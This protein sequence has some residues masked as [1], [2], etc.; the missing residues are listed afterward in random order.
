MMRWGYALLLLF[1]AGVASAHPAP[2]SYLDIY[3]N[4]TGTHGTLTLH[5]YDVAHELGL[6]DPAALLDVNTAQRNQQQLTRLIE[7][8]LQLQAEQRALK[9]DW[10]G[11]EVLAERQ[12]L[13]L[14]F[15]LLDNTPAELAVSAHLFPY[16]AIHQT[17]INIYEAGQLKHQDILDAQ[18]TSMSYYSGSVQ[19]RWAVLRTYL[20][21]GIHHILIG[22]DHILFLFGLLLLGGSLWRLLGIVTAF[23]VGHSITLSLAVLGV[24]RL[25]PSLVEPVI[26]LSVVVVGVDNLLVRKA[27][28][29][30]A[31]QSSTRDL[32]P[33][34]AA[35][36]GLVHGFGFAAVLQE[37]DLPREALAWSLAA[38][39]IGVELGQ[40]VIVLLVAGAL[41]GLRRYSAALAERCVLLGSG[42]VIAAGAYWFVQRVW[43]VA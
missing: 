42:V 39:N 19:G 30:K 18:R 31:L 28:E 36:F 15:Q 3:L 2:F 37:F 23:T 6:S 20:Q 32:R 13:R 33:W 12:S 21:A 24:V 9:P 34:L 43:F 35:V 38:F 16:D 27:I 40:L 29:S 14:R 10:Q 5:D 25:A 11:I 8:R 7:S 4:E 1:Y 17:F 22:P 26:A 41:W